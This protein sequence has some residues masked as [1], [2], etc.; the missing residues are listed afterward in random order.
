MI[1]VDAPQFYA[2]GPDLFAVAVDLELRTTN[3]LWEAILGFT[4]EELE[5]RALGELAHPEDWPRMREQFLAT[6][7]NGRTQFIEGRF[8]ARDGSERV[9]Q[10]NVY[11]A[12]WQYFLVGRD[13]TQIRAANRARVEHQRDLEQ[14]TNRLQRTNQALAAV[15]HMAGHDLVEPVRAIAQMASLVLDEEADRLEPRNFDR[16][17]NYVVRPA[18]RLRQML[19]DVR[20]H[21]RAVENDQKPHRE[22]VDLGEALN[23]AL[24]ALNGTVTS[25]GA[26]FVRNS[27][28][29]VY[30]NPLQIQQIFQNLVSNACKYRAPD[31]QLVI[32]VSSVV[33]EDEVHIAVQDNGRGFEPAFREAVFEFGR[34]LHNAES[35]LWGS[36]I[37][38]ATVRY[39]VETQGGRVWADSTPGFGT[40]IHFTLPLPECTL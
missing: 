36:G 31:R 20:E 39:N 40:T 24:E 3:A 35:D 16:L 15:G 34:K 8:L 6:P 9:L 10:W 5:E 11:L 7:K 2:D 21:L 17:K 30:G 32:A 26:H 13:V 18:A 29:S 14:L 37:G 19:D 23:N 25:V 27:L 4:T 38:L 33:L 1:E 12:D 22:N 28:G